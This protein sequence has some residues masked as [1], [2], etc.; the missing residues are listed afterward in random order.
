MNKINRF[1]RFFLVTITSFVLL[2]SSARCSDVYGPP[3]PESYSKIEFKREFSKEGDQDEQGKLFVKL[4]AA[5]QIL[6]ALDAAQTISCVHKPNC[7]EGNPIFGRRPSVEKIVLMKAG[8]GALHYV[9]AKNLFKE[10]ARTAVSF[11]VATLL[12]QGVVCGLNMR[13]AF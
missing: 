8:F 1:L 12:V 7:Q 5:Y 11:Q 3:N 9:V 10:D 4:E 6:N 2:E 13:H